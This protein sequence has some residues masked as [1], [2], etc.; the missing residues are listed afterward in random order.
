VELV[1]AVVARAAAQGRTVIAISHD[2][3]F[4]G[5]CFGRVVVMRGGRIVADGPPEASLVAEWARPAR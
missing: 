4:V 3:R 1:R 5:E 2:M